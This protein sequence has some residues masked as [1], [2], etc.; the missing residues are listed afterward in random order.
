M[1]FRKCFIVKKVKGF[2]LVEMIFSLM[3]TTLTLSLLVEGMVSL[4]HLKQTDKQNEDITLFAYQ[5]Q[6]ELMS[7]KN[8]QLMDEQTLSY[9][10]DQK[11]YTLSLD[12]QRI[13]KKEGYEILLFDVDKIYF[14]IDDLIYLDIY[15][16]QKCYT[17]II[18]IK[19]LNYG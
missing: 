5:L 9:E 16:D 1:G 10:V 11:T 8:I 4:S 18:G 19:R 2:T 7:A 14:K 15:R 12:R 3:I 6:H 13:V 17:K